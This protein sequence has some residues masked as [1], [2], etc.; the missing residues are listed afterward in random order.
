MVLGLCVAGLVVGVALTAVPASADMTVDGCRIVAH[1]SPSHHTDCRGGNLAGSSLASVD[2][3]FSDLARGNLSGASLGGA[4]LRC[5][6]LSGANV[7]GASLGGAKRGC[8][9]IAQSV[10]HCPPFR[11]VLRRSGYTFHE[12]SFAIASRGIGCPGARRLILRAD[13]TLAARQPGFGVYVRVGRWR[14]ETDRP[15]D[16]GGYIASDNNCKRAGRRLSWIERT[17]VSKKAAGAVAQAA[18]GGESAAAAASCGRVTYHYRVSGMYGGAFDAEFAGLTFHNGIYASGVGCAAARRFVYGYASR[19]LRRARSRLDFRPPRSY[20]SFRCTIMRDGDDSYRDF[21]RKG[22]KHVFFSD[23]IGTYVRR[24]FTSRQSPR[25]YRSGGRGA[26]MSSRD[27]VGAEHHGA[28]A[29][30]RG[31]MSARAVAITFTRSFLRC[32]YRLTGCSH[33]AGTLPAYARA[34]ARALTPRRPPRRTDPIF[35]VHPR[36]LSVRVSYNHNCPSISAVAS[37]IVGLGHG[38]TFELHP[39]LVRRDGTWQVYEVPE[40]R[41]PSTRPRPLSKLGGMTGC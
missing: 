16:H 18:L 34:I 12:R 17:L 6:N 8:S 35:A 15:Y 4:D 40:L 37:V 39:N 36:I 1:P 27:G 22:R 29:S 7:A 25:S 31:R 24:A 32:N 19:S 3:R 38:H 30:A 20:A 23:S 2:L 41:V 21:C 11:A 10:A 28:S 9:S 26:T 14:C 13:A 5:A 33:I